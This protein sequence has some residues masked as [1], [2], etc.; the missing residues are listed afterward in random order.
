MGRLEIFEAFQYS[1]LLTAGRYRYF[2]EKIVK[3]ANYTTLKQI[4]NRRYNGV[5]ALEAGEILVVAGSQEAFSS[6]MVGPLR[7]SSLLPPDKSMSESIEL[8]NL[9]IFLQE[10]WDAG[11]G[12][13]CGR[14]KKKACLK[15]NALNS[16]AC[17]DH[18]KLG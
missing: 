15:S 6:D 7:Q 10:L 5:P 8:S 11:Y 18:S 3:N 16:V 4:G 2:S 9:G 17:R 1:S 12:M 14:Q 13:T